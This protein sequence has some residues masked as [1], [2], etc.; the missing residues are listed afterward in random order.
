MKVSINQIKI[1]G[2]LHHRLYLVE[3][4]IL[5]IEDKV[6]ESYIKT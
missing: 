1:N 6:E 2:K 5:L 4:R 3:E